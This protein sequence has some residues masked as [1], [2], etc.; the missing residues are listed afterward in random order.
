MTSACLFQ[1]SARITGM[2][3][4]WYRQSNP[5]HSLREAEDKDKLWHRQPNVQQA[6]FTGEKT[7]TEALWYR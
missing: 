2:K 5:R 4:I 6:D 7:I 3:K 1:Q